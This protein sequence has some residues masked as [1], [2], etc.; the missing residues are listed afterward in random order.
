MYCTSVDW[1]NGGKIGV[2][3]TGMIQNPN[4][5]LMR[6]LSKL[7]IRDVSMYLF[8]WCFMTKEHDKYYINIFLLITNG[9]V[10]KNGSDERIIFLKI[11]SPA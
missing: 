8:R 5:E 1:L 2:K 7:I 9:F 10:K 11:S 4:F 6:I 3:T